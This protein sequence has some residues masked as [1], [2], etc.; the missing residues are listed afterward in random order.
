MKT[1]GL[2]LPRLT[3]RPI[4]TKLAFVITP[5]VVV[6]LAL[7]GVIGHSAAVAAS[8]ADQ[9]RRLVGDSRTAGELTAALQ[10]ERAAAALVFAQA[11]RPD[12]VTAYQEAGRFTDEV[13]SRFTGPP[14]ATLSVLPLLRE[15]VRSG[16]DVTAS[17]VV[18]R[19]RAMI[20][21][22]IGYRAGMAQL[23]VSAGTATRLRAVATLSDG[24]EAL[25]QLQVTVLPAL[26]ARRLTAAEQQQ[27]VAAS[28]AHGEAMEAFRRLAPDHWSDRLIAQ[29]ATGAVA[30][31][32]R[33]QALAANSPP[34]TRL[35][36]AVPSRQWSAAFGAR[37][38][39]L[40][41]V[42]RALDT[43]LV[44]SVTADRDA[45]HR[46]IVLLALL[47]LSSLV[48]LVTVGW[49]VTRSMTR[50]L[51]AL[52]HGAATTA[53][54]TLPTVVGRLTAGRP[55]PAVAAAL[56]EHA[57][58][59]VPITGTDEIAEVARAFNHV[60]RT[61]V[62]L[63]ADQAE[64]QT[65]IA[66]VMEALAR[67]L[68]RQGHRVMAAIDALE[69]DEEDPAR[70]RRLFELDQRAT[71]IQRL[72]ANLFVFSG[73]RAGQP[74]S[75]PIPLTDVVKAAISRVHNAYDQVDD[76]YVDRAV[77][78]TAEHAE[79]LVHV[80]TE[81]VDNG[82]RFS[83]PGGPVHVA[84]RQVGD[85][86]HVQVS[87]SGVGI[88]EDRLPY[89]LERLSSFSLDVETA[90]HMGL[91][92]VGRIASRLGL[93]VSLR[94]G[95]GGTRADVMVPED[96]CTVAEALPAPRG[97]VPAVIPAP[98]SSVAGVI[99]APRGAVLEALPALRG[100]GH[101]LPAPRGTEHGLPIRVPGRHAVPVT[102]QPGRA[103]AATPPDRSVVSR[104]MAA[105]A[106]SV[107]VSRSTSTQIGP[108]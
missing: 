31:A 64:L 16:R 29:P 56:I 106:A 73:G 37:M 30:E 20:T 40:H 24:V 25:G 54:T 92:V 93:G 13:R 104:G 63:A 32:E 80:L 48:V 12:A 57:G 72:I 17:L 79:E 88:P 3:D 53:T 45:R 36:W 81:L 84:A 46:E 10:R 87:D 67:Q 18:F 69:Q 58:T 82:I 91:P 102:E 23:D 19:Y 15:Q 60:S 85:R 108:S 47:V 51:R 66:T 50:S 1:V 42:E 59:A 101:G 97:A 55:D 2:A 83:P 4:R 77:L 89:L 86:V 14:A 8:R 5:T 70:L 33:L 78:I 9:A 100:T 96:L 6:I 103:T 107:R 49:W 76:T 39:R 75:R 21:G 95:P 61:A 52:T 65:V 68:Q 74:A 62:S 44:A 98:R 27:T 35:P 90:Q 22:L 43:E 41:T 28:A 34:A 94:S 11:S 105:I 71:G 99:P 26:A 7:A 38:D